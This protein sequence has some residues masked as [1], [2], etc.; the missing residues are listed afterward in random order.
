M[1]SEEH[2]H[3]RRW[4]E[5]PS[6]D[7]LLKGNQPAMHWHGPTSISSNIFNRIEDLLSVYAL[8]SDQLEEIQRLARIRENENLRCDLR[9][10]S[11]HLNYMSEYFKRASNDVRWY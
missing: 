6:L 7:Q 2:L 11:E 10:L 5:Y 4:R 8:V 9:I 1:Q 3:E